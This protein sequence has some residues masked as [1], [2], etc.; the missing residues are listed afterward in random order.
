MI[1]PQTVTSPLS[2]S[3]IVQILVRDSTS[4]SSRISRL[5]AEPP[6]I[7]IGTPQVLLD[8]WNQDRH[9]L[10]FTS[11][12]AV[13][14]DEVD[15][16]IDSVPRKPSKVMM[17][18][19]KKKI[20]RHPGATRQLLNEIY[21]SQIQVNSKA[22]DEPAYQPWRKDMQPPADTPQLILSSATLRN[23][24][25]I[26]LYGESG[27]LKKDRIVKVV[28]PPLSKRDRQTL[29]GV[30][31]GDESDGLGRT[32]ISHCALVVSRTGDVKNIEGASSAGD[33]ASTTT[34][35]DKLAIVPEAL[36]ESLEVPD[37]TVIDHELEQSVSS[38][39]LLRF[40]I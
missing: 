28:G 15:Y 21:G 2:V 32:E 39:P 17:E 24:L 40:D 6:H 26:Y 23:H 13:V 11:L 38:D 8:V 4:L 25:K 30:D 9:A 10:Q 12:T 33:P 19:A 1:D 35:G 34:S 29:R 37:T 31:H 27:W 20:D 7:L 14:V 3:P 16:L 36:F 18:R 5:N 22:Y